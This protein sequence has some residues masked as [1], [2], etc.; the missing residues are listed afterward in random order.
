MFVRAAISAASSELAIRDDGGHAPNA[1]LL[2][3]GC[4]FGLVHVVNHYL[5]RRTSYPFDE[6]DCFL[7]R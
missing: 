1:V 6:F 5:V 4:D 7:A 2:C 3:L